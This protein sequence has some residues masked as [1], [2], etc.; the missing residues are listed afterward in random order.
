MKMKN[1]NSYQEKL[2]EKLVIA[3]LEERA[4]Q[5]ETIRESLKRTDTLDPEQTK[6][7]EERIKVHES[8][9]LCAVDRIRK[10]EINQFLS[11]KVVKV[12]SVNK[13]LLNLLSPYGPEDETKEYILCV[14]KRLTK[15]ISENEDRLLNEIWRVREI[16][17]RNAPRDKEG[18]LAVFV[19]CGGAGKIYWQLPVAE[20]LETVQRNRGEYAIVLDSEN[21][22]ELKKVGRFLER[23]SKQMAFQYGLDWNDLFAA[24]ID[25]IIELEKEG[26]YE[27]KRGASKTTFYI[28]VVKNELINKINSEKSLKERDNRYVAQEVSVGEGHNREFSLSRKLDDRMEIRRVM[29]GLSGREKEILGLNTEGFS[30]K[31][32]ALK[33]GITESLVNITLYRIRQKAKNILKPL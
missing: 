29:D 25:K 23:E 21:K 24:G 20:H 9:T 11:E 4:E 16:D 32:I 26:I 8:E 33:L 3:Y 10:K 13:H 27:E 17:L 22:L 5:I 15:E 1:V 31:E 2:A 14:K 12:M 6:R 7:I 19:M 18:R 28:R 30:G